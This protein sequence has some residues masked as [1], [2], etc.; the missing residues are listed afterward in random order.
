MVFIVVLDNFWWG[1][2][3]RSRIYVATIATQNVYLATIATQIGY[4]ATITTQNGYVAT[5]CD[6]N[7][8]ATLRDPKQICCDLPGRGLQFMFRPTRHRLDMSRLH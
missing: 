3:S 7:I 8:C 6:R 1:P 5:L 2:G 4:V